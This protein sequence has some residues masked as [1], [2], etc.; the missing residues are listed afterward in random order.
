[1]V[2]SHLLLLGP[3]LGDLLDEFLGNAI[4]IAAHQDLVIV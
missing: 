4:A 1:M 3:Q 2:I